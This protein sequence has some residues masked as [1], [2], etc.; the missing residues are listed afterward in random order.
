MAGWSGRE[1]AVAMVASTETALI[2]RSSV[3]VFAY[4]SDLRNEQNW[5]VE[6][7][8]VTVGADETSLEVG[9]RYD[10]RFVPFLAE[11]EGTLTVLE[12]EPGA[13]MVLQTD[14]AGLTSRITCSYAAHGAG[15]RFTR[16]V[17]VHP[18]GMLRVLAP[19]VT[20]RVRRTNRRD[21]ANLK[22]LLE[23]D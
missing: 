10:V 9:R 12:V 2:A 6:V 21:V 23:T 4:T 22:R 16:K 20:R 8:S 19:F 1:Y 5:D 11:S 3:D 17:E 14:F 15:T 13:R 7:V 18:V